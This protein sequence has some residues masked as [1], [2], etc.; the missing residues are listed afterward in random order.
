MRARV[1][2]I[3]SRDT[4]NKDSND[5]PSPINT[6]VYSVATVPFNV[7]IVH[8]TVDDQDH[9]D[10]HVPMTVHTCNT[11]IDSSTGSTPYEIIYAR[12]QAS[13][14]SNNIDEITSHPSM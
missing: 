8:S 4:Q 1:R 9:R 13:N 7:N 14:M 3:T 6:E 12:E 11:I 10:K 2:M 5:T